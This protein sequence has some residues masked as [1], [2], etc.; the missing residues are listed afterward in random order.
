[1]ADCLGGDRARSK[2]VMDLPNS[3]N[4]GRLGQLSLRRTGDNWQATD[5]LLTDELTDHTS[6]VSKAEDSQQLQAGSRRAFFPARFIPP[7]VSSF[8][9]PAPT[10]TAAYY[11]CTFGIQNAWPAV[12]MDSRVMLN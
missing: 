9:F 12:P 2:A 10:A 6:L 3:G 1:M 7:P 4:C 11:N 8:S 5:W